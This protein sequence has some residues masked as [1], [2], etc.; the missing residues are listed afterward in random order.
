MS[1]PTPTENSY[2]SSSIKVLKGLDAVRKRPG[3]YIGDTDDGSGLHHMV[4]EVVDNAID[5]AL[6]G[7]CT[8]VEVIIHPDES[9]TVKDNGRGIP[10]D[11]H[12]EEGRSAAEVIM[13]ILHAGGKFDDN[14]YKVSGGLHGVGVSVVNALSEELHLRIRRNQCVYE[15][16]YFLGEPQKPLAKT[17]QTEARGTEIRFKPSA[18]IFTNIKFSYD[19]LAKRL[20][21]L[22][23][24][25][26]GVKIHL[27]DER[28]NKSDLFEYEGGIKAFVEYLHRNKVAVHPQIFY[29]TLQRQDMTVE[30]A[31]QWNDAYQE[32]IFCY[33]NNIPQR[34]GGTHL[35]GFRGALTRTLNNYLE[36]EGFLKKDKIAT[37]GD[38]AR[39]GLT[40][41]LSV[42]VPDPKFSSQ[43]KD[44][45][46]SSEVKPV[47]ESAMSEQFQAYLLENPQSAKAIAAKMIDAARARAAAQRAR[48]L[49]RRKG[50]LDI[51]GLPGKLADCQEKDPALSEIYIVEGES[52]GGSAKQ[53]RD[54]RTQAILPLKGKIL[55]VEKARFDKMI[56]SVEVGT[57]ITALGCGIGRDD[58]N[59]DKL[60]YHSII[61][62]TD[63]DVD[64]SHIR[65]LL[66]T[67]F[68]RQMPELIQ[69]G[70]IFI[71]QP[72]LYRVKRGKQVTYVK[73]DKDLNDY[74]IRIALEDARLFVNP[75]APPI[76]G[77]ALE[78]LAK[79]YSAI[80]DLIHRLSY[81][82]PAAVLEAL[83]YVERLE[84]E[85]LHDKA[86]MAHWLESIQLQLKNTAEAGL[87][88]ELSLLEDLEH[89]AYMP[90]VRITTHGVDSY[91]HFQYD[92]FS[93]SDYH[94]LAIFGAEIRQLLE[95]GS[96]V[97]REDKELR[98]GT[99]KEALVWLMD[100]AKKGQQIQRYKGLG[101]MNP[102]QLWETT[103]DPNVRRMM[104]VTIEDVVAADQIFT[105]LMGDNV[106]SRRVFIE[107]NALLVG[108]LDI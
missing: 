54:R 9:V 6:A 67:F 21:E 72:P 99:F 49:T 75:E 107:T 30:V 47:V 73:D 14:S 20:R 103:M 96:F 42:K 7:H 71:A 104:V 68:Y 13:T 85:R 89:K 108:N 93:S 78:H 3:M 39:E 37:T 90:S 15:Q 50:A 19:I 36:Q 11:M 70:H 61:I 74:L 45:L 98:V 32:N 94:T 100:E 82:Y 66:L 97:Q 83:L 28:S 35:A 26:A 63:A 24:L 65:T 58:F 1:D 60:R 69:R 2:D 64:G 4:F 101:E 25:N 34:D 79:R 95:Q 40:A 77:L 76:S 23:F 22:S 51:A 105:T 46:V 91:Y 62:M 38:D 59:P 57:L 29:F 56:S 5:E 27:L 16:T 87:F 53:A 86:I 84:P 88:F 106:E 17:G 18:T 55:N 31:M 80:M 52:A 44:K 102:D 10:V 41:V 48:E 12:E 8:N 43:T 81:R 92:F 33:T